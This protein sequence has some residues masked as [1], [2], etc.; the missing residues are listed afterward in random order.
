[1]FSPTGI[2]VTQD[3]QIFLAPN[4]PNYTKW[5]Y[6]ILNEMVNYTERP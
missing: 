1:V 4:I 6:I 3:C 5:P 2:S